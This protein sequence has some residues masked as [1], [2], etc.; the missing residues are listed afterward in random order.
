MCKP[1]VTNIYIPPDGPCVFHARSRGDACAAYSLATSWRGALAAVLRRWADKAEGV[2]SF[3]ITASTPSGITFDDV[4][5]A[6]A[7]GVGGAGKYLNDIWR[8][9]A[10][11]VEGAE[12]PKRLANLSQ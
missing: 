3:T 7:F 1:T 12:T 8:E 9:R 10:I 2:R 5:N 11:E 4:T 6:V